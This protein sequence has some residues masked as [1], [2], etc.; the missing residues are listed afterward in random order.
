MRCLIKKIISGGQ[1]GVDRAA[2]DFAIEQRIPHGGFCPKGRRA[3]DGPLSKRYQLKETESPDYIERTEKNVLA[4]DGTLI[5]DYGE[6]TGGTLM[7]EEFCQKHRKACFIIDMDRDDPIDTKRRFWHWVE[8]NRIA[9]L[10]VAGSRESKHPIY[11]RA[12][13]YLRDLFGD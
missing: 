10:N 2:L 12:K 11:K 5:L 3:E 7:T 4:S 9:T 8:K 1:T 6:L 13:E